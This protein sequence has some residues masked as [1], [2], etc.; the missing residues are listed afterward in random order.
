[1]VVHFQ[2]P[3]ADESAASGEVRAATWAKRRL[4]RAVYRRASAVI[5]LS[6]SFRRILVERYAVAP[7]HIDVIPPGVDLDE[8]RRGSRPDARASLGLDPEA[9]IVVVVRRLVERMGVDVLVE[10]WSR[11]TVEGRSARLLVVGDGPLRARL[12]GEVRRRG[13]DQDVT[14]LGRIDNDR[15][16][17]CYRAANLT[18]VPSIDLEGYGLVV[19]ES[20][21]CGTPVIGTD[22]GG[23]GE[24]LRGLD[25]SLTV[26][27]KDPTAL[28]TRLVRARD[29]PD[30]LPSGATCRAHAEKYGWPTIARRTVAVY[31]RVL[32]PSVPRRLRI[33]FVDHCSLLSGG[34]VALVRL[35][36]ALDADVHVILASDGPL[37]GALDKAGVSVEVL[38][39]PE[40]SRTVGRQSLALRHLP[41]VPAVDS[42]AY[43]LR[44]AW[45]LRRLRPDLV[46]TNSLKAALYG[47]VAA[48]L[49]RT[50]VVWHIRDRIADDYLPG[51]VVRV[52]RACIRLLPNAIVANSNATLKTLGRGSAGVRRVVV[53]DSV[54]VPP[55]ARR[56][57]H[58]VLRVGMVGRLSPW[59]GQHLYLEAF[60]SA[61]PEGEQQAVIIGAPLFGEEEYEERLHR[62]AGELGIDERV[63]FTGW[64]DNVTEEL[65][66]LDVLVHASTIPEPFGLVV[67]EGLAAGLAVVAPRSGGPAEVITHG[68]DG[69]LYPQ[70]DADALGRALQRLDGDV[71]LRRRLG[72]NGRARA[73]AFSPDRQAQRV[74]DFYHQVLESRR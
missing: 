11:I 74:V 65:A 26:H 42:V 20:L 72:E 64:K 18:V 2:G 70:G 34:E 67:I 24:A 15:L 60:A 14:F 37:V 8:F 53:H 39:L 10:A 63:H 35:L 25:P 47:G 28:A 57:Q 30:S 56:D 41:I 33:V 23:L 4:E 19:L 38:V 71:E 32:E 43:A 7:W 44:L 68:E 16:L 62:Q 73:A 54:E 36:S 61:F 46:H 17:D 22:A 49:A 40:R 48:R 50:P 52:L 45:K 21:A 51:G 59:K 66:T 31:Q 6:S 29:E 58:G 55:A 9:W 27:R 5:V 12:E 1:L 13:L 3:W 69:L